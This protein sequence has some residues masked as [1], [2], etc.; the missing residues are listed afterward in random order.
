[1]ATSSVTIGLDLG[2]RRHA[3]CV[4]DADGE[5]TA[6]ELVVNTRECLEAFSQ[7]FPGAVI[8]MVKSLERRVTTGSR[9]VRE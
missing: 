4:L 6:E 7:R 5:I 1:M 3:A 2:D 8:A 9:R